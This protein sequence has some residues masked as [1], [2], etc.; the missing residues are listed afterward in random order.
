MVRLPGQPK[1]PVQEGRAAEAEDIYR[2]FGFDVSGLA[3]A[4]VQ[5]KPWTRKL[6]KERM[7]AAAASS[8]V[9]ADEAVEDEPTSGDEVTVTDNKSAVK[10]DDSSSSGDNGS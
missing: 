4:V 7:A 8:S 3:D 6:A 9:T 1:I 5:S 2:D 10:G